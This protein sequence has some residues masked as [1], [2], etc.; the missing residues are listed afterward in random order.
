MC[1]RKIVQNSTRNFDLD[2]SKS[3][4]DCQTSM[5]NGNWYYAEWNNDRH[6]QSMGACIYGV[7]RVYRYEEKGKATCVGECGGHCQGITGGIKTCGVHDVCVAWAGTSGTH[8]NDCGG[9]T[10]VHEVLAFINGADAHGKN[11]LFKSMNVK[12]W[13]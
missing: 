13:G 8:I 4:V 11:E 1:F 5:S 3:N 10:Y 2:F 9:I 7:P 6:G 12:K